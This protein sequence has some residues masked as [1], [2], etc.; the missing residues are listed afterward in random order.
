[1]NSSEILIGFGFRFWD[2]KLLLIP[3]SLYNRLPDGIILTSISG[4]VVTKGIEYI[5]QDT[6]G[7]MLAFG[8]TPDQY[9]DAISWL[10]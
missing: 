6:R 4:D 2:D 9:D 7:G 3:Q 8:V 1:M 10:R 5:D